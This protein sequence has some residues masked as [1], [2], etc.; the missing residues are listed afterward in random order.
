MIDSHASG[1]TTQFKAAHRKSILDCSCQV[2]AKKLV[3]SI[4][5]PPEA[6]HQVV[7][8][9]SLREIAPFRSPC[10]NHLRLFASNALGMVNNTKTNVLQERLKWVYRRKRRMV[11]VRRV[12]PTWFRGQSG[13]V[14]RVILPIF[15]ERD[16]FR[17]DAAQV[18]NRFAGK[19]S[20]D[21]WAQDGTLIIPSVFNHLREVESE[22]QS[23][24]DM[25]AF[26][27]GEQPGL[28]TMGWM[29][30]MYHSGPQQLI[31]QD[32]YCGL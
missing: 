31:Y 2:D 6:P 17:F 3:G 24:F 9:T 22:I 11:D 21:C 19:D 20:W 5:I 4:M 26:H 25:Y 7:A 14:W 27:L 16:E 23:E 32:L 8:L 30:N 29:R 12:C 15:A 10:R 1:R 28:P 18:F 13:N